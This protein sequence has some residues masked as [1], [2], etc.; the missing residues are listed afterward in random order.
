MCGAFQNISILYV[1]TACH[2]H[3]ITLTRTHIQAHTSNNCTTQE[4]MSKTTR[5]RPKKRKKVESG[6]TS[7][8]RFIWMCVRTNVRTNERTSKR[9]SERAIKQVSERTSFVV[10]VSAWFIYSTHICMHELAKALT[11]WAYTTETFALTLTHTDIYVRK[12]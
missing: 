11:S 7:G 8:T 3:H 9:A 1:Y 5:V 12:Y 4:L 2:T 6:S 10:C